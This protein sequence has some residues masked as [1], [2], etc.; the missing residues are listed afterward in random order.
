MANKPWN[1]LDWKSV[2]DIKWDIIYLVF[3]QM[4]PNAIN[5]YLKPEY[6]KYLNDHYMGSKKFYV[7]GEESPLDSE[8]HLR[9]FICKFFESIEADIR[10]LDPKEENDLLYTLG[11]INVELH[12]GTDMHED[13]CF[14]YTFYLK[15]DMLESETRQVLPTT[16]DKEFEYENYESMEEYIKAAGDE[17]WTESEDK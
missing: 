15:L 9:R 2:P 12:S 16:I 14:T 10:Y 4:K 6:D 17:A 13:G 1:T 7:N 8:S 11:L 5:G 3:Q